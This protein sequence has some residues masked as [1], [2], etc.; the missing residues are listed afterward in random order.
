MKRHVTDFFPKKTVLRGGHDD[1]GGQTTAIH[2]N[3]EE[4]VKNRT[5]AKHST[6]RLE[7]R[8]RRRSTDPPIN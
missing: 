7:C 3:E 8:L 1:D 2:E 5:L 4:E 6:E